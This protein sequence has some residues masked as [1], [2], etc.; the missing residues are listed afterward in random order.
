MNITQALNPAKNFLRNSLKTGDD[1]G[2]V[3]ENREEA[4]RVDS[5]LGQI[6]SDAVEIGKKLD[7][8]DE[9]SG[10]KAPTFRDVSNK[11]IIVGGAAAG[12][13]LGGLAGIVTS[14]GGNISSQTL[15]IMEQSLDG[16]GFRTE[17]FTYGGTPQNPKGWEVHTDA[18]PLKNEKVGEYTVREASAGGASNV[19]LSG[20][21]GLAT[22][23]LVGAGVGLAVVGARKVLGK[24]YN[25]TETR[26]TEGDNRVLIGSGIAGA[27]IGAGAGAL[28]SIVGSSTYETQSITMET[29]VLGQIP[30]GPE[31][32][33]PN[34]GE[35]TVPRTP[36]SVAELMD[37]RVR[38]LESRGYQG[39]DAIRGKD[40]TGQVPE[41]NLFGKI[42]IETEE[43][44][45]G[46][47]ASLLGSMAGGAAV[48]AITGVAG[49]V[50]INVLR[51]TL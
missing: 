42:K 46:S 6:H 34:N 25:G 24:D 49:G 40:V 51:K 37:T 47:G 22:G 10:L 11:Q 17:F 27:V 23:A 3:K 12:A 50:L 31:F 28:S 19:L 14:G 33:V 16:H 30:A 35:L 13:T 4:S 21:L 26:Q 15:P 43:K 9:S 8:I 32:F 45:T 41:R 36:E 7:N 39:I 20:G 5:E 18:L 2:T 44:S 38:T 29:K 48:G 1:F